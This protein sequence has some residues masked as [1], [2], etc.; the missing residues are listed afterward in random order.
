M[1]PLFEEAPGPA[2]DDARL[3]EHCLEGDAAAWHALIEKYKRLVYAIP[4][5]YGA[6]PDAAEDIFQNVCLELYNELPRLRQ[7]GAIRGWL[8]TVASRQSL[9]WKQLRQRR[10]ET[11]L[12]DSPEAA[13]E[14][15]PAVELLERGQIV[16]D[17]LAR[18]PDR[19][20]RMLTMLFLED[21]PRAYG[22][23]AKALGLAIGS[24]GF[25]R[26]RCMNK[27]RTVLEEAGF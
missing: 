3:V 12:D 7:S 21:P 11:G 23:V 26:G 9:R 25:I 4:L 14:D 24:I 27:L 15:G 6:P 2:W 19:C 22:E 10:G 18:L 8:A 13:V 16:H 5:R 17:A 20:R 1:I